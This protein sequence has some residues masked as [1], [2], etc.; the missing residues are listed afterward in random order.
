M[1]PV[2]RL[3]VCAEVGVKAA[4]PPPVGAGE[5]GGVGIGGDSEQRACAPHCPDLRPDLRG[6]SLVR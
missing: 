5:L 2:G 1:E 3:R 6:W 4:G